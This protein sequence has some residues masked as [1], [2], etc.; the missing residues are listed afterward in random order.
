M[1]TTALVLLLPVL[2]LLTVC[3]SPAMAAEDGDSACPLFVTEQATASEELPLFV[4]ESLDLGA[5]SLA[6]TVCGSCSFPPSCRGRAV[7]G[8]CVTFSGAAGVCELTGRICSPGLG[9]CGCFAP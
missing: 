8:S 5:A 3:T 2:S 1:K 9:H 7:G 6:S 4:P